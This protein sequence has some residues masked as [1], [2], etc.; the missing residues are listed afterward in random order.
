MEAALRVFDRYGER[1]RRHKARMK[2]LL[3]EMGLEKFMELVEAERKANKVKE[4]RV[5]ISC[6][7]TGEPTHNN[8][9]PQ[10]EIEKQTTI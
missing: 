3:K 9:A 7:N 10:V 5:D 8:I 6:I 4:F 2:F 1:V